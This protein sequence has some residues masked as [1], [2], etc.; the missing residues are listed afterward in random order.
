VDK[1]EPRRIIQTT[2]FG[3]SA[4]V[5]IRANVGGHSPHVAKSPDGKLWFLPLDGV[6]VVDP[7]HLPF[8]SLPPP[9]HIEQVL[10]D[11]KTYDLASAGKGGLRLPA[12][13]RDVEI[14]Y[15]ALSLVAP[16][17]VHFQYKLQG[18]D[19]DWQDAGNRRQAYYGNL[20]PRHYR[21][22]VRASNNSGVWNEAG[23]SLDFS[24]DPAYYQTNLFRFS[25]AAVL[26]V[27]LGAL[28]QL[29]LRQLARQFSIRLEERVSERTRIARD[30]HDTLLQSF[31]G[32]LMQFDA[33]AYL[34]GDHPE[35][36]KRLEKVVR[37]AR[38]AITE[39]RDAVQGLRS[40]TV[41]TNDLAR[42]ISTFGEEL[43]AGQTGQNRPEF[44]VHVE[45]TP[46]NLAPIV[47][48]E[49]YRIAGEALRNAFQH[50]HA[51]RIEVEIRYARRQLR[52]RIRDN[53]RGI[54]PEILGEGGCAGHY[55]LPGMRERAGLVGGKLAFSSRIDSGT[56]AELTIPASVAYLRNC[57]EIT[58]PLQNVLGYFGVD[59]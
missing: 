4:G 46:R 1:N 15:A 27:L 37:Q 11:R 14:D 12:L 50:A 44:R 59:G 7:R 41:I 2:V 36:R 26:L 18:W 58:L 47:R 13:I 9:V 25:G 49:V 45:G 40:S 33:V 21:F 55:G 43:A 53:G 51:G 5:R 32:V 17:E 28:Y 8:N 24:I 35:A 38:Q 42:A 34:L 56:E 31:Q 39:G 16:E 57:Y 22:Q 48:D 54:A 29:R 52:L 20:P 10:A 6:S 23:A 19:R 30:L 3:S